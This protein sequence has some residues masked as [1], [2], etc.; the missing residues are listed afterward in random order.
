[1]RAVVDELHACESL[2]LLLRMVS[3]AFIQLVRRMTLS[4]T[5]HTVIL[6]PR[7]LDALLVLDSG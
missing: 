7:A 2:L 1:L 5:L 3:S 6:P 4:S